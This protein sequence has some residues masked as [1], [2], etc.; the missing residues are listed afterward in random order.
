MELTNDEKINIIKQHIKASLVNSFNLQMALIEAN[1]L[2]VKDLEL[3]KRI[4]DEIVQEETKQKVLNDQIALL[5][6]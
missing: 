1:A 3:I 5:T 4:N 2:A 6:K